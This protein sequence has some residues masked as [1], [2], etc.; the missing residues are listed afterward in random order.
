[1]HPSG[2]D[3][4]L[5]SLRAGSQSHAL[6][7]RC[8]TRHLLRCPFLGDGVDVI[9]AVWAKA[10]WEDLQLHLAGEPAWR[11]RIQQPRRV[12]LRSWSGKTAQRRSSGG[13]RPCHGMLR[14]QLFQAHVLCAVRHGMLGNVFERDPDREDPTGV[15]DALWRWTLEPAQELCALMPGDRWACLVICCNVLYLKYEHVFLFFLWGVLCIT[16]LGPGSS[17][18]Q[19]WSL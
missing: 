15:S 13:L 11:A 1:M 14:P 17:Q 3:N 6:Y 7:L 18:V 5:P 10:V 8:H 12:C 16:V 19:S 9:G 4:Q 2:D